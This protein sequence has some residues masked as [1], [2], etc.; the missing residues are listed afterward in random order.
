MYVVKSTLKSYLNK[1]LKVSCSDVLKYKI[2]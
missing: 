2:N 1:S